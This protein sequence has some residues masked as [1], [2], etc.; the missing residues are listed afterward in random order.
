MRN[1]I[2]VALLFFG[3]NSVFAQSIMGLWDTGKE[4]TIIEINNV[5]G[6]YLGVIKSSSNNKVTIGKVIIKD[7][8]KQNDKWAGKLFVFKKQRWYDVQITPRGTKLELKVY[9][10][11]LEKKFYWLKAK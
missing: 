4:N 1:I 11:F 6:E 8:K 3:V 2:V 7:L 10:G 5:Q 9:S